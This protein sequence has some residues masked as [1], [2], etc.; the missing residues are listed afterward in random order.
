MVLDKVHCIEYKDGATGL[1]R[2]AV[3]EEQRIV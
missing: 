2:P 3:E 1:F